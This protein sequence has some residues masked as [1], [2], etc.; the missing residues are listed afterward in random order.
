MVQPNGF[1]AA[2]V[3]NTA[4]KLRLG[5]ACPSSAKVYHRSQPGWTGWSQWSAMRTGA[6]RSAALRLPYAGRLALIYRSNAA[7]TGTRYPF[8]RRLVSLAI[9]TTAISSPNCA[10]VIPALAAAALWLAMQ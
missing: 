7:S 5:F 4:D 10:C 9:P 2:V 3:P 8:T 1:D 6:V